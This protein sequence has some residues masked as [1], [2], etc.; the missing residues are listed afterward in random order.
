MKKTILHLSMFAFTFSSFQGNAQL[1]T[2]S[3]APDWT[4]TD[5]LGTTHNLYTDLNAGKTVFIDVS[6]TWCF[7]FQAWLYHR[8]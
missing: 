8:K 7:R 3:T 5:I 6:A 4:L 1:A 2:G